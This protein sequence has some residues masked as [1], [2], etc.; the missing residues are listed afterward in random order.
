MI[1]RQRKYE[2]GEPDLEQLQKEI[3]NETEEL[4]LYLS[5]KNKPLHSHFLLLNQGWASASTCPVYVGSFQ[6]KQIVVEALCN[7]IHTKLLNQWGNPQLSLWI[8]AQITVESNVQK[9]E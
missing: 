9:E 6:S 1:E 4:Y 3:G 7:D 8:S 5:D 2:E